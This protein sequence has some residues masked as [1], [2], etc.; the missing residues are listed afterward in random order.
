M[1]RKHSFFW[2]VPGVDSWYSSSPGGGGVIIN[3]GKDIILVL[4][5]SEEPAASEPVV[6]SDD[7]FVVERVIGQWNL[8]GTQATSRNYYVHERCYVVQATQAQVAVRDIAAADEADTSFMY[9]QV[10]AW[11]ALYNG[12]HVG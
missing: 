4:V 3:Q 12:G 6:P 9:H 10:T 7:E 1:A 11:S 8:E 5:D 2:H